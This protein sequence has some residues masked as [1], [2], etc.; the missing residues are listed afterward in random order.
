MRPTYA[1]L[2]DA[3]MTRVV[4]LSHRYGNAAC[5]YPASSGVVAG[6]AAALT[7][8]LTGPPSAGVAAAIAR[9]A[10]LVGAAV[11]GR[12]A[13]SMKALLIGSEIRLTDSQISSQEQ[14]DRRATP[15][16]GW[17]VRNAVSAACGA[18]HHAE[19]AG[20]GMRALP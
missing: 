11:T 9:S 7:A 13:A 14:C 6:A 1:A 2:D 20:R 18:G 19:D 5:P 8:F 17:P 15:A 12:L 16:A 10:R 3:T 4:G